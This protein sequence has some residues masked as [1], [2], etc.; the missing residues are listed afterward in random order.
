MIWLLFLLINKK[1]K[2][3]YKFSGEISQILIWILKKSAGSVLREVGAS[4]F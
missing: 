3:L 1:K 4:E 2:E